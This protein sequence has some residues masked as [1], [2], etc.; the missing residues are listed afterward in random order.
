MSPFILAALPSLIKWAGA[1][2]PSLIRM[3]GSDGSRVAERNAQAVEAVVKAAMVAT[4]EGNVEGATK[5]LEADPAM[6]QKYQAMLLDDLDRLMGIV[7]QG[8]QLD[9]ASRDKAAARAK[10]EAWD[11]LPYLVD[12]TERM[13][14]M[15]LAML[16]AGL[17][18]AFYFQ[19]DDAYIGA[20]AALFV[21]TLTSI[22]QEW[23]RPREYRMGSSSGS[24]AS[25]D[26]VRSALEHS[27]R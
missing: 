8:E 22:V 12:R 5:A 10:G 11:A 6:Q 21:S 19:V 16:G 1:A 20:V 27:R 17:V 4:G 23:R 14:V 25:G 9:E 15:A 24:K 26:A 7:A 18:A 2:A 13:M 3:F